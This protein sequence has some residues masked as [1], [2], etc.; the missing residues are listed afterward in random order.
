MNKKLRHVGVGILILASSQL[1]MSCDSTNTG[2]NFIAGGAGDGSGSGSGDGGGGIVIAGTGVDA[3]QFSVGVVAI[4]G[5]TLSMHRGDV[6]EFDYSTPCSISATSI[7]TGGTAPVIT[8][9]DEQAEEDVYSQSVTLQFNVP[10]EK[11]AYLEFMPPYYFQYPVGVGP[12]NVSYTVTPSGITDGANSLNGQPICPTDFSK[13]ETTGN[14]QTGPNCCLGDYNLQVTTYATAPSGGTTETFSS[15]TGSWGGNAADCLGGPAMKT[16]TLYTD[17]FPEP[18]EYDVNLFG[19]NATY[20]IPI[21]KQNQ[22]DS[23]LS[24]ANYM[25]GISQLATYDLDSW[26]G[27]V[28]SSYFSNLQPAFYPPNG[29]APS[30]GGIYSSVTPLD[31]LTQPYY[32]F[33]CVDAA[34][35]LKARI[36]VQVRAWDLASEVGTATSYSEATGVDPTSGIPYHYWSIWPDMSSQ[37]SDLIPIGGGGSMSSTGWQSGYPELLK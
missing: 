31:Y 29:T 1:L 12:Q 23:L 34:F 35:E 36:L 30:W 32:Q 3:T 17:G 6:N 4:T 19:L 16:Q 18:T 15:T 8:C 27:S 26:L 11:C 24:V 33:D 21:P 14:G 9:I 22:A 10:P 37:D 5:V 13:D 28:P 7:G 20:S 2:A 25:P